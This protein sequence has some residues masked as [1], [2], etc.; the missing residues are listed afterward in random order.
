MASIEGVV[1]DLEIKLGREL[2]LEQMQALILLQAQG[3][4]NVEHLKQIAAITKNFTSVAVEASKAI[5]QAAASAGVVKKA[6]LEALARAINVLEIIAG[7]SRDSEM[8]S[9]VVD[10]VKEISERIERMDERSDSFFDRALKVLGV[11]GIV[12]LGFW[13]Q[14][15]NRA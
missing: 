6:A 11:F 14:R 1:R 15:S 13:S 2:T 10:A 7:N 4:I 9:K 12:A 3:K 5:Y 8:Q